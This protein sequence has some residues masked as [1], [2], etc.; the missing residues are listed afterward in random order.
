MGCFNWEI[1]SYRYQLSETNKEAGIYRL[2]GCADYG[3]LHAIVGDP[4]TLGSSN[5][6]LTMEGL[7]LK[8][9]EIQPANVEGSREN[10]SN[11]N[12][13]LDG[14]DAELDSF[15]A[16][17]FADNGKGKKDENGGTA[18][19]ATY[20]SWNDLEDATLLNL[21]YEEVLKG[22]RCPSGWKK[23][24]W[25]RLMETFQELTGF[26]RTKAHVIHSMRN[27]RR[28]YKKVSDIVSKSGF[29][30]DAITGKIVATDSRWDELIETNKDA[31]FYRD[32]GCPSYGILQAVVGDLR[33]QTTHEMFSGKEDSA[34]NIVGT[35]Q[36]NSEDVVESRIGND[37]PYQFKDKEDENEV[38]TM[39]GPYNAWTADEDKAMMNLLYMEV[40]NGN[41]LH[42]GWKK[43]VWPKVMKAFHEQTGSTKSKE[44]VIKSHENLEEE[45]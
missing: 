40:L 13:I 10:Q 1:C 32:N 43:D 2:K 39:K 5:M 41:K 21:L 44:H 31:E 45:V 15:G 42:G 4:T 25:P 7:A 11:Q 36:T 9:I 23:E 30:W 26:T 35:L 3:L 17:S 33:E 24:V 29:R 19:N 6:T 14:S 27:W 18:S 37:V 8:N 20:I 22:N 16:G 34:N 12:R 38:N 28:N